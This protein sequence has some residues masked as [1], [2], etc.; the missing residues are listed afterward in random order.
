MKLHHQAQDY[1][2]HQAA[3]KHI[4]FFVFDYK[5]KSKIKSL[6]QTHICND[7]TTLHESE[8]TAKFTNL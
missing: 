2:A 3:N 6:C 8:V 5:Q 1:Y 7:N 4:I